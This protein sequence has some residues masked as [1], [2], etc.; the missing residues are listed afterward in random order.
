MTKVDL[1]SIVIKEIMEV[2]PIPLSENENRQISNRR[3]TGF[4]F[5]EKGQLQYRMD[6]Q[7]Y[8]SDQNHAILL[9]FGSSYTIK[10]VTDSV[11]LLIDTNAEGYDY[12]HASIST[13]KINS[14]SSFFSAFYRLDNIWTFK[15]NSYQLKCM[16]VLYDLLAKINETNVLPYTPEYKF[17]QIIP[18]I[19]YLE[20]HY[21]NPKLT[22]DLLAA[23][24]NI[25]TVYF[26]KIFAEKY[27]MSPMKYVKIKRIEKAQE[28]LKGNAVTITRMAESVGFESINS[29]SRSFKNMTGFSP[30]EYKKKFAQGNG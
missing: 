24:S 20:E 17:D 2:Y 22:N 10:S 26:R 16:A 28:M 13:Y 3:R 23:Q 15:K 19:E 6:G 1:S 25:S 11:S 7:T 12:K 27:V 5:A 8:V 9:P 14:P 4:I 18:S 21:N 30:Q 29:F